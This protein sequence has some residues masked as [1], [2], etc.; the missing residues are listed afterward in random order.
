MALKGLFQKMDI[1]SKCII[2][3]KN[4]DEFKSSNKTGKDYPLEFMEALLEMYEGYVS[5]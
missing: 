3:F 4:V 1:N 5:L 2:S